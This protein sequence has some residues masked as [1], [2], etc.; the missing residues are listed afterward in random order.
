MEALEPPI[1]T[2][3]ELDLLELLIARRA[4]EL[5]PHGGIPGK[6]L[7]RWLQAEREI[8]ERLR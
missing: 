2:P 3:D 4:D 1:V 8:M 6:D 7:E 5:F